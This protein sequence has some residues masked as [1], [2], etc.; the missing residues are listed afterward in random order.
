MPF[1]PAQIQRL[2]AWLPKTIGGKL[3]PGLW[4]DQWVTSDGSPPLIPALIVTLMER[5]RS[6]FFDSPLRV[7]YNAEEGCYDDS[8]GHYE[9]ATLT[10]DFQTTDRDERDAFAHLFGIEIIKT[11]HDLIW[12]VDK[13]KLT[14]V[15]LDG[16]KLSYIDQYGRIIYR[17]VTD[18]EFEAEISWID[19]VPAITSFGVTISGGSGGN[20]LRYVLF[21]P[22]FWGCSTKLVNSGV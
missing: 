19:Q 20:V 11:R 5:G 2:F 10:V 14:D 1:S 3:Y 12:D 18:I 4:S 13:L 6:Q 8:W 15:L 21:A 22:G 17:S 7:E 16:A 9:K